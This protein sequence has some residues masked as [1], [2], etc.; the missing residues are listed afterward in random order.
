[1]K[2][3]LHAGFGINCS[4][5]NAVGLNRRVINL[6]KLVGNYSGNSQRH[7]VYVFLRNTADRIV[8]S[9]RWS[10]KKILPCNFLLRS[11]ARLVC[12]SIQYLTSTI[13]FMLMKKILY[14]I[15]FYCAFELL[16]TIGQD[17]L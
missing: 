13:D 15:I 3:S 16:S 9:V 6:Q 12:L 2:T 5:I 7:Y 10:E 8:M 14:Y 4:V 17:V 11:K 1:M